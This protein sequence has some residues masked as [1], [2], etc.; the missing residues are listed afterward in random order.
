MNKYL[1]F[2]IFLIGFLN[3]FFGIVGVLCATEYMDFVS[4][5]LFFFI[6]LNGVATFLIGL[7]EMWEEEMKQK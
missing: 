1:A 5:L 3:T 7:N 6:F 2:I 4:R